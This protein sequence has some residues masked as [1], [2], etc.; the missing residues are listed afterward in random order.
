MKDQKEVIK[1]TAEL[2]E[3]KKPAPEPAKPT[4]EELLTNILEELKKQNSK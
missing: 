4:Q 3:S 2:R 1:A